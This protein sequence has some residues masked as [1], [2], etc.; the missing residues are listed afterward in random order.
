MDYDAIMFD[1][2][3]TLADTLADLAAAGN[4]TL[5]TFG[6]AALPVERYRYLVGQGLDHLI[7]HAFGPEHEAQWEAAA[8]TFFTYYSE[9]K[10]DQTGPYA[11]IPELL[12]TLT[13]RDLKLAVLSNKPDPATQDMVATLFNQWSWDAVAGAKP[14][15]PLK[16]EA[17]AALAIADEL[18][19]APQR[20]VYVGDTKV[21]MLTG[22]SAGMYTVGVTWGFRDEAEL[23]EHGAD[24]IIHHPSQLLAVIDQTSVEGSA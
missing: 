14:G 22:K 2:D 7:R 1:L 18:G 5:T 12:D 6:H 23:R 15:V 9:H 20:W 11:G 3:G 24:A 21:D 8:A 10:Y 19:I 17:G 13:E 16:P 4:H